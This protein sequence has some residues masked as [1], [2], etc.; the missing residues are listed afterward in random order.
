MLTQSLLDLT[1]L[2]PVNPESARAPHCQDTVSELRR[3]VGICDKHQPVKA[4]MLESITDI[5]HIVLRYPARS[6]LDLYEHVPIT[7]GANLAPFKIL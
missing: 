4:M 7:A 1:P 5:R 3:D 6:H 2:R